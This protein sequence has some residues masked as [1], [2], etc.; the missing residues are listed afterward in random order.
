MPFTNAAL[1]QLS[2]FRKLAQQLAE[3]LLLTL[4]VLV[5]AEEIQVGPF[6]LN[7]SLFQADHLS[8]ERIVARE[9]LVVNRPRR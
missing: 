4:E 1:A 7:L 9:E 6:V 2:P 5:L 3:A 8:V